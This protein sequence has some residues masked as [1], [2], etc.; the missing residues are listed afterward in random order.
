MSWAGLGQVG[1]DR[2]TG[3]T[4]T[5]VRA[6]GLMAVGEHLSL[7][8]LLPSVPCLL[9][10]LLCVTSLLAS[11]SLPSQASVSCVSRTCPT[12]WGLGPP[13]FPISQLH[14]DTPGLQA[15]YRPPVRDLPPLIAEELDRVVWSV[16]QQGWGVWSLD[17]RLEFRSATFHGHWPLCS[18]TR[19]RSLP[20]A[21]D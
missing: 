15:V 5:E 17:I 8:L 1:A 11:R 9:T 7:P 14:A 4:P 10:V 3:F 19:V 18:D 20:G 16:E 6:W 13:L 12:A 2:V 21:R